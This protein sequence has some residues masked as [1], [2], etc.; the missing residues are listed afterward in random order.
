MEKESARLSK[1]P[2]LYPRLAIL[3]LLGMAF[4]SFSVSTAD[5]K[6]PIPFCGGKKTPEKG[7]WLEGDENAD[8]VCVVDGDTIDVRLDN[9]N[10]KVMRVRLPGVDC[11]ETGHSKKATK[12]GRPRSAEE[13]KEGEK[14]K[15][16]I[17]D[18]LGDGNVTLKG[19]YH[20]DKYGRK[21]AY[22]HL[23]N[24]ID[25]GRKLISSCLCEEKYSHKR[26]N[27]YRRAGNRCNK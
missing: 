17:R 25:L 10:N 3:G 5:A 16:K 24:G 15:H 18:L 11:A 22:V 12:D 6:S 7:P 27:D 2:G 13:I 9:H 21:L 26:K 19:P 8:V 4:S 1:S 23:A 20:N 14:A